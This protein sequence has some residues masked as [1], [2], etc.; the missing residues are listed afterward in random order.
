MPTKPYVKKTILDVHKVHLLLG[1]FKSFELFETL[2]EIADKT[3]FDQKNR[4]IQKI[5]LPNS[6]K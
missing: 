5:Y 1:K 3:F 2:N 4:R 6:K